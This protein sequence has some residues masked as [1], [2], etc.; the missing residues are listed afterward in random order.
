MMVA[1]TVDG[2]GYPGRIHLAHL[3]PDNPEKKV[4]TMESSSSLSRFDI[5]F[6]KWI[7][8]LEDEFQRRQRSVIFV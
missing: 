7:Q 6:E 4:W 3:L 8:S 2:D 5:D 1:L